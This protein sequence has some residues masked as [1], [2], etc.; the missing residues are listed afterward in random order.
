VVN[1][2]PFIFYSRE[3]PNNYGIGLYTGLSCIW[4]PQLGFQNIIFN[5]QD[6]TLIT[7]A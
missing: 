4:V 7:G 5:L 2:E 6:T 3:N 1:A